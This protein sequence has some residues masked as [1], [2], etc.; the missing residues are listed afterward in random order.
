MLRRKFCGTAA[1]LLL[2]GNQ[3]F[4]E[5]TK[6]KFTENTHIDQIKD[7]KT[8]SGFSNLLFPEGY[9][10]GLT[11]KNANRLMPYHT[12]IRPAESARVLNYLKEEAED[13]KKIFFPLK[14]AKYGTPITGL[15]FF[16]GKKDAPFAVIC[17]GGGFQYVGALHEGFPLALFLA[18]H[19]MNAFVLVYR[20][21][22]AQAACEDLAEAIDYIFDHAN[23]IGVSTSDYSLWGGSAGARMAAYLGSYTPE[24]FGGKVSQKPAAVIMEY[25]G[26]TDISRDEP[27]T[28]AVVGDR[29]PIASPYVM[30]QRINR[31]KAQGVPTQFKL[32][33]G[34]SHGFGLGTASPAEGW[35]DEA[36]EFWKKQMLK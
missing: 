32:V 21:G 22:S 13:G 12:N 29:D 36:L 26:H 9:S 34:I 2:M 16:Q 10:S 8:F 33:K 23:E 25:T 19:G 27:A 1:G 15:F 7:D 30:E 17:P 4:S 14:K 5:E 6:T 24:A 31:L 35:A 28:F 3:A 11:L 20:T 18:S